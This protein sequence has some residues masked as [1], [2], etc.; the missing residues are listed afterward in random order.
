MIKFLKDPKVIIASFALSA[1]I[2]SYWPTVAKSFEKIGEMYLAMLEM[3]ILPFL[4]VTLIVSVS[5]LMIYKDRINVKRPILYFLLLLVLLA[6]LGAFSATILSFGDSIVKNP[7]FLDIAVRE[8]KGSFLSADINNPL[9]QSASIIDILRSIFPNNIFK[10]LQ[11]GLILQVIF[12]SF[13]IG[14]STMAL[15]AKRKEMLLDFFSAIELMMKKIISWVMTL[16]PIGIIFM[17]A[18][19]FLKISG[20]VLSVFTYSVVGFIGVMILLILIVNFVVSR[21]FK[22]GYFKTLMMLKNVMLISATT[23]SAVATMPTYIETLTKSFNLNQEKIDLFVPLTL[24]TCRYGNAFYFGFWAVLTAQIFS[25]PLE[26]DDWIN[27]ILLVTLISFAASSSGIVN[28]SLFPT[29]LVP[30]GVPYSLA[31]TLYAAFDVVIDPFR[32]VFNFYMN[33]L[34]MSL[35]VEKEES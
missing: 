27:L 31:I 23:G 2:A 16:L 1:V 10:S 32:T 14:A 17:F 5:K 34:P 15:D 21:K 33:L 11:S 3:C 9:D 35:S 20:E 8:S 22:L 18:P 28:L 26:I 25:I 30:L 6:F 13:F 24:S 7:K 29:I 19:K 4:F 12:F